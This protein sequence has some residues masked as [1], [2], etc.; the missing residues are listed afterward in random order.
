MTKLTAM[1]YTHIQ[2]ELA[3]KGIGS[4]T[5]SM[6]RVKSHGLMVLVS[7]VNIKMERRMG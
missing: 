1:V 6:G 3:T 5:C 4:Q 2:M 7:K